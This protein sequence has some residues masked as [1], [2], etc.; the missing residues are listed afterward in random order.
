[1]TSKMYDVIIEVEP[2]ADG[3]IIRAESLVGGEAGPIHMTR[4]E[5]EDMLLL[6]RHLAIGQIE[7]ID[8]AMAVGV[9]L[10]E[11][12]FR[13]SVRDLYQRTLV[14]AIEH[15]AGVRLIF[16]FGRSLELQEI[17]WELLHNGESFLAVKPQTSIV[18][19]LMQ[20]NPI[21]SLQIK[22]PI[23]IL[24]TTACPKDQDVLDLAKEERSIR[25]AFGNLKGK[26][27]L[28]VERHVSFERLVNL[29]TYARH[30]EQPFHLW[31]H[32]GHGGLIGDTDKYFVLVLENA[33]HQSQ[34]VTVPQLRNLLQAFPELRM[35]AMNICHG[36]AP[37]GLAPALA[38][39]NVPAVIGFRGRVPDATS[40][41][42]VRC[43]Y[44]ALEHEDVDVALG[45]ARMRL[46]ASD[47]LSLDWALPVLFLRTTDAVLFSNT[48]AE[49]TRKA[50]ANAPASEAPGT[51][52]TFGGEWNIRNGVLNVGQLNLGTPPPSSG[53]DV[54]IEFKPQS[55]EA[56]KLI[57][58]GQINVAGG[59]NMAYLRSIQRLVQ[60]LLADIG[61]DED[62]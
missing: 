18:R 38:A 47:P 57:Q 26:V 5:A 9:R 1:M 21:N 44:P 3:Y 31:H 48:P 27:D 13:D 34:Y 40:L 10:Y 4:P 54:S 45:L 24:F 32:C 11:F 19:Y 52:I 7:D 23:R 60:S 6:G 43:F 14:V 59:G 20:P 62:T 35:V 36:A 30:S 49:D 33:Q 28:T 39:L 56:G 12:I 29:F 15:S 42:F 37:V 51:K 46:A 17:P 55:V 61:N 22:P 50:E 25:L 58:F 8:Q 2:S 16:K 41:E 53:S